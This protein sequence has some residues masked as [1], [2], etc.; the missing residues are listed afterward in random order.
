MSN[1]P[2]HPSSTQHLSAT[3]R[4]VR[5]D[6]DVL[7]V[8]S[9]VAGLVF[10]L[11][12]VELAPRARVTLVSK[13]VLGEG[14]S[15]YAQGGIS[16]VANDDDSIE[17]H[18]ADTLEAGD[19]LCNVT[20][21]REILAAAPRC[22]AR[23]IERGVRFDRNGEFGGFDLALEGGHSRRRIYHAGDHTGDE[24]TRALVERVRSLPNVQVIENHT[25]VNLITQ[26]PPHQ[27]GSRNEVMGAYLLEG[28]SGAIHTYCADVTVLA[29]GGAGKVYRYTTNAEIA[30][31]DGVAMAYRAGARIGN[32]EFYQFHPTLLYH[33]SVNNCLLT[34][35][36]RGEGAYLRLPDS[37]ER[38]MAR[39]E[40][41]RMELAT[42]DKVA[43]AIFTEIERGSLDYVHLDIRHRDARFIEQHFPYVHQTLRKL[44]LDITRDLIPVVPAAHYMC[45]G[46]LSD[47][48]G[49]SD[50]ARLLVVGEC[51]FTGM[52]GANRLASNS[53]I[54]GVVMG[55]QAAPVAAEWLAQPVR[56]ARELLDWDSKSVRD[57][58]RLSQLNANWRGLRGEMMS[59][60]GI[61]R[62]EQGL[63]DLLRIVRLRRALIEEYY[64]THRVTRDLVE[65][66]NIAQ[67][68]ELIARSALHRRESRGGHYREDYPLQVPN[69]QDT[70]LSQQEIYATASSHFERPLA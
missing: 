15:R 70:I 24:M 38:F 31:G 8:G 64:W 7:I 37:G 41:E 16:A 1:D 49:R 13:S 3:Q 62:T 20:S 51:A 17:Q 11:E 55:S 19:G 58:R 39:Y 46:V 10:A 36:L 6:C 32:M 27:P 2:P 50:L 63:Q 52:H 54:E 28:V 23:L 67:V 42:R 35:A 29:T 56:R 40:P 48:A 57:A 33:S 4:G 14:N 18:V 21:A 45:G 61:V 9:G 12:L 30:T 25:A 53:L 65:L 60:A 22:I 68:S 43:R 5:K 34:E 59:Y 44:G 66:R 47:T 26:V 69:T